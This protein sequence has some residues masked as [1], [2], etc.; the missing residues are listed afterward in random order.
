MKRDTSS[1]IR[2]RARRAVA[3]VRDSV[4]KQEAQLAEKFDKSYRA[5]CQRR[6]LPMW[7]ASPNMR[8]NDK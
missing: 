1:P 8:R 5:W 3:G 2:A 6:G 4:E 7:D